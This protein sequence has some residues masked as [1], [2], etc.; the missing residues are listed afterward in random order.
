MDVFAEHT[1]SLISAIG[2]SPEAIA[3]AKASSAQA[4]MRNHF[5][6]AES[7]DFAFRDASVMGERVRT[8]SMAAQLGMYLDS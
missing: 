8:I 4:S 6:R 2:Q 1:V 5:W 7:T 3:G